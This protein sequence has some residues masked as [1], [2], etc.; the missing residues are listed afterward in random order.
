MPA[1]EPATRAIVESRAEA[2]TGKYFTPGHLA[3]GPHESCCDVA[4]ARLTG[5]ADILDVVRSRALLALTVMM[6][7]SRRDPDGSGAAAL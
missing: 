5:E 2:A 1:Q 3:R 6:T 4:R 7:R